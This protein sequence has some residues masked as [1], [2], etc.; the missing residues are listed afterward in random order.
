VPV[1]LAAGSVKLRRAQAMSGPA[2]NAMLEDAERTFLAIRTEAEGQPEFRLG[3]GEIYARLGKTTESDA[4]FAA[5]LAK[6]DPKLSLH[7]A[8]VYRDIGSIARAKQ[9]ASQVF[10]S[11]ASPVKEHAASLLGIITEGNEGEAE[12]WFHKA[13]QQDPFVRTSLL[14]LEGSRLDREGKTVECAAKFAAAAKAHLALWPALDTNG[15]IA[16]VL[17]D[18]AGLDGDAKTWIAARRERCAEA[19]LDKL[20]AEHAPLAAKI[21]A[22]K[23]WADVATYA[24]AN[25]RRPDVDDLRIASLLGD[26]ALEARARAVL[27]DKLA[28]LALELAVVLD[29]TSPTEKEDLVYLDRR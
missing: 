24:R 6:N 28:H 12:S 14:E 7:V 16:T 21:R 20:V 1:S 26:P 25:T 15:L 27:D 18:E 23:Q 29:P 9:I 5:I 3:L 10:E 19:A 8:S 22:A 4:E 13:D 17:I 2:R 11:A